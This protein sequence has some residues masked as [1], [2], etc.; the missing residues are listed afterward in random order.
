MARG[1]LILLCAALLFWRPLDYLAELPQ[2]LPSL[3][4]RGVPGAIEL[5]FHGIVAAVAVAAV[6]ALW[7]ER[8]S[9]PI[10]AAVALIGSAAATVQSL[11]WTALPNQT[12]PGTERVIAA[13]A[14][15]HAAIWLV[16]LT[17]SRH[18]RKMSKH[19]AAT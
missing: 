9:G 13:L 6:Q 10:L 18:I 2:S 12:V 8:P 1:W 5:L 16:Y 19:D 11:Y 14:I 7:N 17:R 15:A 4:M 3:G